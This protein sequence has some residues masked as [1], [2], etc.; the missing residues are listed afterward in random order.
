[1]ILV[2]YID[3]HQE[4][5]LQE[6]SAIVPAREKQT[7]VRNAISKVLQISL[8]GQKEVLLYIII[9]HHA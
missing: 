9:C 1:M 8:F 7:I 3:L 6:L 2:V 5:V 4:W